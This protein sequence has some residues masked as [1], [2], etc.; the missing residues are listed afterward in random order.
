MVD[1]RPRA[2]A[3]GLAFYRGCRNAGMRYLCAMFPLL[4]NINLPED[5]RK[6]E[7]SQ[8]PALAGELRDFTLQSTKTKAGHIKSSLGVVELTIA[9]H[10]VF[11][12]PEDILIWDVGHQAYIHKIL[13]GRKSK[14][15]GNR[16]MG[17]LSG[18]T[19]RAESPYDPFGAGHSSTSVSAVTG[20]AEADRLMGKSREY[21]AVIGDGA[22]TG[23]ESFEALNYLGERQ[24]NVTV[25]LNDNESSIDENVG[26]LAR[27]GGY[28][29]LCEA[30]HLEYYCVKD[31]HNVEN[32]VNTFK[33]SR[34][35]NR[36]KLIRVC[37]QK[38]KGWK[39]LSENKAQ[40]GA[41]SF[42]DVFSRTLI[43]IAKDN[44]KVV[45][46]T[47]AMISGGGLQDFKQHFPNRLFDVGIAEQHAV[48]FSAAMAASGMRPFCH[49][50]STF[51][52]R[53][54][55]QIIHD[56]VLQNLP[57]VFCLDRA[58][59]VGED[60]PT[61][62]GAFDTGFLNTIPGLVLSAPIDGASLSALMRTALKH[63]KPFVI[64]YPKGGNFDPGQPEPD[65]PTGKLRLLKKGEEKAVISYGAIGQEVEQALTGLP[66]S[67]YDLVFLKPL[68]EKAL[69]EI[70]KVYK[71]VLVVEENSPAGGAGESLI[72]LKNRAGSAVKLKCRSLPDEF[73]EHGS[74]AQLL[75]K[76]G[77]D[78]VSLQEF[79][80]T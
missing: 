9:L 35:T 47:P 15:A 57:V 76:T 25:V 67:H 30:L 29:K 49:L 74:R 45:A 6:L 55:D 46:V 52:Q 3:R 44:S 69:L 38:G 72:S 24:L 56:V 36:P 7:A 62:H 11:N 48:T 27:Y 26:A 66:Y 53:A 77:L 73:I 18:F 41:Q 78:S 16:L 22:L 17:G 75:R 19:K 61:H 54:Y 43:E 68:D 5:L 1:Q 70:F 65:L 21:I 80:R 40:S 28:E 42:Q 20:F 13:T 12:T 60:G 39:A 23:G 37:T 10:Y 8:L 32:L 4:N 51:A 14:F 59:L 34:E 31:G 64:R 63:E 79:F 50:Y 33:A 58:G 2:D 71:D